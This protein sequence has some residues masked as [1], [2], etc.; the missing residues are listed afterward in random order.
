MEGKYIFREYFIETTDDVISLRMPIVSFSSISGIE[1]FQYTGDCEDLDPDD[2]CDDFEVF[3]CTVS[4][5]CNYDDD[6]TEDDGTC[7]F[8]S[9]AGC[10]DLEACN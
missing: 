9:C 5:A 4:D 7:E 2:V 6:A 3:I 1:V 8:V 10:T